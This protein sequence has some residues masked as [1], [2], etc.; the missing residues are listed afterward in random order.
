MPT[1][2]ALCVNYMHRKRNSEEKFGREIRE[3]NS[4]EKLGTEIQKMMTVMTMMV[5]DDKL[6]QQDTKLAPSTA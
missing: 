2:L 5:W 1:L 6:R 4:E 3:R